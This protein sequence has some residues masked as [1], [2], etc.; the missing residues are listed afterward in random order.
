MVTSAGS[1]S[2][3]T[4]ALSSYQNLTVDEKLALLWYVYTKMGTSVTPAAPGAAGDE[5]ARGLFD[6]VKELSFEEQLDV[7]RKLITGAD[8]LIS[9]EYGSLSDN[10]KLL[11]WYQLAQGMDEGTIVPVPDDYQAT[12]AVE[13]LLSQIEVME[14]EQQITLLR[15]AVT[16]AGGEPKSGAGI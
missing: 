8:S 15:D 12:G 16:E 13:Q 14:F 3:V 4:Q 1:N 5:I 10:T 7:Q 9:R 11:F 6:Q 2:N